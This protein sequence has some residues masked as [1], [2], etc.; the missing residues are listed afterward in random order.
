MTDKPAKLELVTPSTTPADAL[1]IEELWTRPA[2]NDALTGTNLHIIPVAKPKNFFRIP[3]NPDYRRQTEIYAHRTENG[4]D[5]QY[6][7]LGPKMRGQLEDAR[8]CVL[9][10]CIYRD[11]SLRLW[12]LMLPREDERD[13]EAWVSAR[14]GAK[15]ALTQWVCLVWRNR[16][17]TTRVAQPGYAPDP[18]WA[19]LPPFNEL[20]RAAMGPHGIINDPG[21]PIYRDLVGAGPSDT[22]F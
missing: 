4:F 16:A 13:N 8:P 15:Q 10:A 11:N 21:H 22:D 1:D 12:P 17:Y 3:P 14:A 2:L 5:T 7:I 6:Y 9:T 19:K 20:V 18:D